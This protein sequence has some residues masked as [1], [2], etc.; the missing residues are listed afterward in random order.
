MDAEVQRPLPFVR[1]PDVIVWLPGFVRGKGRP[2]TRVITTKTGQS[3][4]HH[5]T[6]AET[7]SYEGQLRFAAEE[8]MD[9]R[10]AIDEMMRCRVTAIFQPPAS[11]LKRKQAHIAQGGYIRQAVKP[12]GDNIMKCLD[13]FKGVVWT[14]DSRVAEWL[15]R[16]YYGLRPGLLVEVWCLGDDLI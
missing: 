7:R 13:A 5:Y 3:F 16:K 4:A 12:D 10:P 2:R 1:Q 6:D 8:E 9:G 11:L 14:D 15:I